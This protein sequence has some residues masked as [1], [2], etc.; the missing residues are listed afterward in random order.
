[1]TSYH[2]INKDAFGLTSVPSKGKS[3]NRLTTYSVARF[4]IPSTCSLM[5]TASDCPAKGQEFVSSL[6]FLV[7]CL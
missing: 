3:F 2:P 4:E 1:M 7:F 6:A 5:V